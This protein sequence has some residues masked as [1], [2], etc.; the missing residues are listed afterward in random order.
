MKITIF[1]S[2]LFTS[3]ILAQTS[4]WV[5]Q[6]GNT[7]SYTKDSSGNQIPDFSLV[8]YH[9]GE[10]ALPSQN[11]IP[12]KATVDAG[13]SIQAAIDQVSKLPLDPKTGYRGA[14]LL[15]T[16]THNLAGSVNVAT[17]GV[18]L[19]GEGR[20]KTIIK[21]TGATRRTLVTLGSASK[22]LVTKFPKSKV[23]N[24]VMVGQKKLDVASSDASLFK[25]GMT[26]IV[27]VAFN[28]KFILDTGMNYLPPRKDGRA[29]EPW[30]PFTISFQRELTDIQ[31]S[32]STVSLTLDVEMVQAIRQ[33]HGGATIQQFVDQRPSHIGFEDITL[34]STYSGATDEN[35]AVSGVYI[36]NCVD[37]W[38]RNSA[39][40]H[41]EWS[42]FNAARGSLRAQVENC[43]CTEHI[44]E[45]DGGRRYSFN[46]DGEQALF[47]G[48]YADTGRHSYVFGSQIP[49]PNV[50]HKC[51]VGPKEYSSSEPHHRWSVGGLYDNVKATV[52]FQ[53]RQNMGSG[54]GWAGANYVAWNTRGAITCQIPPTAAQWSIGHSGVKS[55]GAFAKGKEQCEFDSFGKP[56][57]PSSLYEAQKAARYGA[58]GGAPGVP[59]TVTADPLCK[60]GL[61]GGNL[62]CTGDC[63]QCGG[64]GCGSAGTTCCA[65]PITTAGLSCDKNMPPCLVTVPA[66]PATSDSLC[67]FGIAGGDICCD[68]D[69]GSCGGGGCNLRPGGSANCCGGAITTAAVSCD[70]SLAPCIMNPKSLT[71]R[72]IEAD[73]SGDKLLLDVAGGLQKSGTNVAIWTAL[74]PGGSQKFQQTSCG[75][76]NWVGTKFCLDVA[77]GRDTDGTN[78]AIWECNCQNPNQLFEVAGKQIKWKGHNLCLN[79]NA[80]KLVKGNNVN[81]W[82]CNSNSKAQHWNV[83][84]VP[85]ALSIDPPPEALALNSVDLIVGPLNEWGAEPS[86]QVSYP[87]AF[88]APGQ[89]ITFQ[90]SGNHAVYMVDAD[91]Y[92]DCT[93]TNVTALPV[94]DLL[95]EDAPASGAWEGTPTE[96]FTVVSVTTLT[97]DELVRYS[98]VKLEKGVYYFVDEAEFCEKGVKL[99]VTIDYVS[100]VAGI[101]NTPEECKGL[102]CVE[103]V[104]Q[105][106]NILAD[107]SCVAQGTSVVDDIEGC[108]DFK[109]E[110]ASSAVALSASAFVMVVTVAWL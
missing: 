90:Y 62:C 55:P 57:S 26:V 61:L 100:G 2:L 58:S 45:I 31:T 6:T 86:F 44:S 72:A 81:M 89:T 4:K 84:P 34:D 47:T 5:K 18:V 41:F 85:A 56:V 46:I 97:Q 96:N 11:D 35:H 36:T 53:D 12:V 51:D 50:F 93:T 92:A 67:A 71:V 64:T 20:G 108:A 102:G 66:K 42:C 1:M 103:C 39:G 110:E 91:G 74:G 78:V 10:R 65:T 87:S 17:T 95:P 23:L 105:G 15:K 60:F 37:C 13:Q 40:L 19:R 109:A 27:E 98:E 3:A 48:C 8:G 25:K 70:G 52:I 43:Q 73:G 29:V 106:C 38:A 14:V 75:L 59:P 28:A 7:L 80:G 63:T 33:A 21:G 76:I 88:A 83:V 69:C 24:T 9:G 30:S 82:T 49:G 99:M 32:G 101:F 94:K 104:S 16:G 54:H 77:G 79:V 107:G 22:N 68:K